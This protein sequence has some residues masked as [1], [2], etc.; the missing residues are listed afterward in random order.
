MPQSNTVQDALIDALA[1]EASYSRSTGLAA[2][3]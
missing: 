2:A 3:N 1:T